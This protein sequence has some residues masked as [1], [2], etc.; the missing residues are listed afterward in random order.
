MLSEITIL[1]VE[2]EIDILE[3][4]DSY[5]SLRCKEVYTAVNGS[6]ALEIYNEKKPDIILTDVTMP[7]MDGIEMSKV[8]RE[9]NGE[10]PI[11]FMT[12]L[13]DAKSFGEAINIGVD[14]YIGKPV[15]VE[16]LERTIEKVSGYI[17]DKRELKREQQLLSE[18]KSA[19]DKGALVSK[20]DPKG[21]ITYANEEF[22]K[23]SGY[24]LDELV[25][26]PH[27]VVRHP[28]TPSSTFK[29]MWETISSKK[30]WS[31]KYKNRAKDGS[32]YYVSSTI[33]PILNEKN[34]IVEFLGLRQ[35]ITELEEYRELLQQQLDVSSHS[36]REK[37]LLIKEYED[38]ISISNAYTRTDVNGV[39]TYV[40]D[41]FCKLSG[42]SRE[43]LIGEKH[44][45][46]RDPD[47][48]EYYFEHL[49]ETIESKKTWQGVLRNKTKNNDDFY[50]KTSIVPILNVDGDVIEYMSI[51][52]DI[53]QETSLSNEII[54]TQ[55]EIVHTMGTICET[56]S[57]ETG[58]HVKRVAEY[59]KLLALGY[60]LEMEE[61][62]LIKMASPMHDI[63]KVAIADAILNKP[64]KLTEDEFEIMKE[65]STLGY[66]M[67]K[68][69]NREILKAA[70]TIAHEHHEKYNGRGYPNG[71][72]GEDIH[73]YG[74]ITAIADVFDAL[75]SSRVYKKAWEL[76]KILNLLREERGEH[77][78]PNLID[79]FF[80]NI[81]KFLEV[82][83]A[84]ID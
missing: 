77:F 53:T 30:T 59:S 68:G 4:I 19:I 7:V 73:I 34:E 60:G 72:K 52:N 71:K 49:W 36:L 61:A 43:E 1:Y 82:R 74:R 33:M 47:T 32:S 9:T 23:L 57:K 76:E 10:I 46:L 17:C 27:N 38:A 42:F 65:H 78:D 29:E 16:I 50:S 31:G 58:N 37:M 5:L 45:M 13:S 22:V 81:D 62:E 80:E 54:S 24:E 69:S 67:L 8:I 84:Y 79:V 75:G 70:S 14:G 15:N 66:E 11:I 55:R 63:G 20:T 48:P 26:K 3:E 40:N 41:T 51:H 44:S 25:G 21:V 12:A 6:Q 64:G 56:R 2:D 83:N 18:Y 28:D 39:I 35:D